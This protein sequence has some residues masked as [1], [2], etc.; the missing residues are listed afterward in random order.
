MP[1]RAAAQL[2]G[3]QAQFPEKLPTQLLS[4]LRSYG[5][6]RRAFP[7][8]CPP[9]GCSGLTGGPVLGHGGAGRAKG[10]IN[11]GP[12][13]SLAQALVHFTYLVGPVAPGASGIGTLSGK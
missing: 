10:L 5:R 8:V 3:R 12:T 4:H 13:N 2:W 9:P 1:P 7:G 6:A 11:G